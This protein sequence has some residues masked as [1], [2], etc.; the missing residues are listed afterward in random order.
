MSL[1]ESIEVDSGSYTPESLKLR[2]RLAEA[3]MQQGMNVGPIASPWQGVARMV[4]AMMGGYQLGEL[5]RREKEG[6]DASTKALVGLLGPVS[7][8]GGENAMPSL[9]A[10]AAPQAPRS[11]QNEDGTTSTFMG[12]VGPSAGP[13][14][15]IAPY[16]RA[17]AGIETPGSKNPYGELGPVVKSGDRAYGKYQV[18]GENVPVWTKQILGKEMTPQQFLASPEA[19]ELVFAGK[20]GEYVQKTGSPEAAASMWFTGRPSAPNA[21]A[22]N[23]D[24]SPLGITGQEYVDKFSAGMNGAPAAA[25]QMGNQPV[26]VAQA[27][28]GMPQ[29]PTQQPAAIPQ[30]PPQVTPEIKARI[31][32]LLGNPATRQLGMAMLQQYVVPPKPMTPMEQADLANK[33]A[34][35]T[36]T[37]ADIVKTQ[38]ETDKTKSEMPKGPDDVAKQFSG[39]IEQLRRFP[40]E[41]GTEAFERAQGPWS[42]SSAQDSDP[43]GGLWGTG[44]SVNSL[45]Q[46]VARGVGEAKAAVYGGA[47]PTEVRDRVETAMKNLAA[48]MKPMIRKP[49]EGAWSDKDQANLEAQI[50]QLS[51][52]RDVGEYRRRLNDIEENM[53]KIFQ[54]PVKSS[55]TV[56][57]SENAPPT[58]EDTV[59]PAERFMSAVDGALPT[60]EQILNWLDANV[61]D[62]LRNK[63]G[64]PLTPEEKHQMMIQVMQQA[65]GY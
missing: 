40:V 55:E 44:A 10:P 14:A 29:M 63:G 64:K 51:R 53:Q 49:G 50:G 31:S 56:I 6:Q 43:Q 48:V 27:G 26:R 15:S 41:F 8:S 4:Q 46:M 65:G 60:D 11:V 12:E 61:M 25:P 57:R 5:E 38:A 59:T 21:R 58:A 32:A 1:G 22:R 7:P 52:V 30:L 19:Q 35:L 62:K 13:S 2:R 47:A 36:K 3:M 34:T 20:F 23:P 24:G 45:G 42:A 54:V 33:Q 18:M 9:A 16:A 28:G 37:Q 39:G 17:I